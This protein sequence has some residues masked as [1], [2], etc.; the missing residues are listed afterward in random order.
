MESGEPAPPP[1]WLKAR[2]DFLRHLQEVRQ[3][4]P[5]T[6]RAYDRD[7]HGFLVFLVSSEG[8]TELRALRP[9]RIRLHLG[10]L[11][12]QGLG[13]SSIARHLSALRSFFRWLEQTGRIEAN[14]AEALRAPRRP[15]KLPRYLEEH[16]VDALLAA[17]HPEDDC[18]GKRDRAL[19]EVLY[20]TGCRASELVGLDEHH[21]DLGR[22]LV[23]LRGKGRKERFGMIGAPAVE[24]LRLYLNS[25]SIRSLDRQ[26]LFLNHR[27]GRLS[28]RSLR[29]VLVRCLQRAGLCRTCTPH[30]LRHSFATHLLRRGADLRTVQELLGHAS[31]GTTQ[32][33]TH[34]DL[35]QLRRLYQ[36]AHPMAD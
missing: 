23:L 10:A 21:L 29:R 18:E 4:S 33:Y 15:R 25:K 20:S 11:S 5:H 30:T 13:A 34:V 28:D 31:L 36:Q 17:P 32:I 16:E 35:E 6:L 9:A 14:P 27:G 8:P 7:Q 1:A 3:V 26:A 12:A 22:G 19:L 24:A 2:S